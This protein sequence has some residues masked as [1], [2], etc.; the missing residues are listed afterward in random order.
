MVLVV[1]GHQSTS[2]ES[3]TLHGLSCALAAAGQQQQPG[4]V[5]PG[6]CRTCTQ[7]AQRSS[8]VRSVMW[9]GEVGAV[10]LQFYCSF[11]RVMLRISLRANCARLYVGCAFFIHCM[12]ASWS[13]RVAVLLGHFL[14]GWLT[15][16][17]TGAGVH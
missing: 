16:S 15:A 10:L 14:P 1:A 5:C 13:I 11:M 7:S 12:S 9:A 3:L 2:G 17:S 8:C 6:L 4:V